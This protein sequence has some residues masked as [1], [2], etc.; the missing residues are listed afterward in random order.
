VSIDGQH[1]ALPK[2]YG[3]P[4]Y[5]RPPATV[6]ATTRPFDPDQLPLERYR[7][8]ESA[9]EGSH[10]PAR[11][12]AHAIEAEEPARPSVHASVDRP[13]PTN[14]RPRLFRLRDVAGK[15]VRDK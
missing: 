7:E 1:I 11:V 13:H 12:Y 6:S 9:G 5:A 15:L 2:L 8:D 4:A 3:A 14:L 10:P